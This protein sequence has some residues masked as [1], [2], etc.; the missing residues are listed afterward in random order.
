VNA[1]PAREGIEAFIGLGLNRIFRLGEPPDYEP[2]AS[3]SIAAIAE[4]DGRD[5]WD[6]FYDLLLENDGRELLLRPLLGYSNF[7]QDPI[8]ENGHAPDDRARAWR[9]RRPRRLDLR[10]QHR[11]L[12]ADPL[13][14][15]PV[16]G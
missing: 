6:L 9:R 7:T 15:R 8:R 5:K 12:H 14:P 2:A 3:E 13:G 16:T 1:R 4:R 10:R 11:D